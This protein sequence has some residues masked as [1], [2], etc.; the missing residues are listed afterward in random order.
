MCHND[1]TL[2]EHVRSKTLV[3]SLAIKLNRDGNLPLYGKP[4]P[5]QPA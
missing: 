1:F 2:D 4:E 3:E 5:L